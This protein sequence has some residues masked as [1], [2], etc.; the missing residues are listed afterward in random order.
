[1]TTRIASLAT[2]A[3]VSILMLHSALAQ[4]AP[5]THIRGTIQAISDHSLTVLTREGPTVTVALQDPLRVSALKRLDISAVQSGEFIGTAARRGADGKLVAL[6]VL[7]F[8]EAGRGTGEGHFAWDLG[9]DTTMTNATITSEVKATSGRELT[10]IYKGG[11][12]T[13]MVPPDA[14]IISP[15]PAEQSD[16]KPGATV[17][18]TPIRAADGSLSAA[19]IIVGK[20]G[21]A[22]PL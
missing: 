3:T 5:Q 12:Q 7:V 2:S 11:T 8:P 19:R 10:L 6:E 17:F 9:P 13:V 16:L 18:F 22:L 15:A 4:P 14:P 1:M 21:V 20:D